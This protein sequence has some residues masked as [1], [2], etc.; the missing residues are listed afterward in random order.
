MIPR[1]SSDESHH[2]S[3][4]ENP[5]ESW[6]ESPQE[7]RDEN[8]Q[9]SRDENPQESREMSSGKHPPSAGV[10]LDDCGLTIWSTVSC[11]VSELYR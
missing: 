5:Q 2:E 6:D 1:M 4:D 11:S 10:C 3:R 8:P 7:S 9:E